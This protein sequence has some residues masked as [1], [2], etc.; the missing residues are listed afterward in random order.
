MATVSA[1]TGTPVVM[2]LFTAL[3]VALIA[4]V[5][6]LGDIASVANAGTLA[7]FIAVALSMMVLRIR[8]PNRP[9][10]FKAPLWWLIGPAAILGCC[11]FFASLKTFTQ[12]VFLLW[13]GIGL[14]VYFLYSVR[15]SRLAEAN[16]GAVRGGS[17]SAGPRLP[18]G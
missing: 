10:V 11:V 17:S 18:R 14:L 3:I 1:K 8:E 9:R 7:A 2:T 12:E 6:P 5:F 15:A 16:Q 4:G 13:N